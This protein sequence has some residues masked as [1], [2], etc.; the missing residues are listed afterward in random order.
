MVMVIHPIHDQTLEHK[1]KLKEEYGIEPWT[2]IQKLGDA[3]L[4]PAGCPHQVRNLK[5]GG[6]RTLALVWG[7]RLEARTHGLIILI[8]LRQVKKMIVH[9][10]RWL[11]KYLNQNMRHVCRDESGESQQEGMAEEGEV[12]AVDKQPTQKDRRVE[13]EE[14]HL[15]KEQPSPA[16][17]VQCRTVH[18]WREEESVGQQDGMEKEE[19]QGPSC[20]KAA[21]T[22]PC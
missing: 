19:V 6:I 13:E 5:G 8:L 22:T 12:Q 21:F 18:A 2:F 16:P 20:C 1:R 10:V 17:V 14:M 9:S 3:V 15:V 4:I 11:V 7:W